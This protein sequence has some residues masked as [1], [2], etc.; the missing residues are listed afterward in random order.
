MGV[1]FGILILLIIVFGEIIFKI[2]GERYVI[3]IVFL[4]VILV[5]FLILIFIFLVWLI[6]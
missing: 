1:F 2:L 6:E 3:N 4:I 5:R